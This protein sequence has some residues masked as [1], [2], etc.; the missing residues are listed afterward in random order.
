LRSTF[1][2]GLA[3]PQWLMRLVQRSVWSVDAPRQR[4][5]NVASSLRCSRQ[6]RLCNF[7]ALRDVFVGSA[8]SLVS[9]RPELSLVSC[10]ICTR[11]RGWMVLRLVLRGFT[12][13]A[14]ACLGQSAP[15]TDHLRRLM[16][17]S[18]AASAD[19]E[20][21]RRVRLSSHEREQ[22]CRMRS[23]LACDASSLFVVGGSGSPADLAAAQRFIGHMLR[24]HL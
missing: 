13:C 17:A 1:L 20:R 19:R 23:C 3:G 9:R 8:S 7:A 24:S 5:G 18:Q 4:L 2:H 21:H 6:L 10:H 15:T 22:P 14:R 11:A 12:S 16:H